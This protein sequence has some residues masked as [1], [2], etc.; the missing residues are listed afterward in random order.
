MTVTAKIG[1]G[2]LVSGPLVVLGKGG[3][4][5]YSRDLTEEIN[6]KIVVFMS[7]VPKEFLEKV[8]LLRAAGVVVPSVH[9][10]DF[11]YFSKNADFSLLVLMK[12]GQMNL[13]SELSTKLEK[14]GGKAVELDGENKILTAD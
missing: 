1:F 3:G 10:R 9:Y 2:K 11:E 12:F 5:I 7:W 14:L 4:N 6:E 8:N 13:P